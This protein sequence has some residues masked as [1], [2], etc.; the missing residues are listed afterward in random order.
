MSPIF[1]L[2][3]LALLLVCGVVLLAAALIYAVHRQNSRR[4]GPLHRCNTGTAAS[5]AWVSEPATVSRDTR[6]KHMHTIS[7]RTNLINTIDTLSKL[8]EGGESAVN[9]LAR[10]RATHPSA[11]WHILYVEQVGGADN[12]ARAQVQAMVELTIGNLS[13]KNIGESA[14]NCSGDPFLAAVVNALVPM[15]LVE[16][17]DIE[18]ADNL[19]LADRERFI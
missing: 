1:Q 13:R 4:V 12:A 10:L 2:A 19:A 3:L 11:R 5:S 17:A 7:E 15:L 9:L 8:E 16:L 18:E 14:V 6:S